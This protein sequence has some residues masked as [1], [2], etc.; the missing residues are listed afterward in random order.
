MLVSASATGLELR[1]TSGCAWTTLQHA[2]HENAPCWAK[3]DERGFEGQPAAGTQAG[4]KPFRVLITVGGAG[5]SMKCRAGCAW[6]SLSYR[7]GPTGT[8]TATVDKDG[9]HGPDLPTE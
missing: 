8:C 1:C 2:C 3:V 9:V 5:F 7:C 4:N 6:T